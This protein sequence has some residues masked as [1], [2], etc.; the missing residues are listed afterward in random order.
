MAAKISMN[1]YT[2]EQR[3]Q[4]RIEIIPDYDSD[5][6]YGYEEENDFYDNYEP[7]EE[8]IFGEEDY[9]PFDP[10]EEEH[11]S[12]IL[13]KNR[14]VIKPLAGI[15]S[16]TKSINE[17]PSP[18]KSPTWWDITNKIDE[19]NRL[20]NGVLNYG[21]LL[22][23]SPPA[24][25][26]PVVQPSKKTKKN[27]NKNDGHQP[28]KHNEKKKKN[29]EKQPSNVKKQEKVKET[30]EPSLDKPTR[31]CLS[32]IKKVKCF[33]TNCRFAHSYNDLKECN[34][35]ERCNK[36]SMVKTNPDGTLEFINKNNGIC[37]FKHSK[38]SK[39]SYLKRVPQQYTKK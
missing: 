13:P 31:F 11:K 39:N 36:I 18:K 27:K 25:P 24:P 14:R 28:S 34:F 37:N 16:P 19:S 35:G 10:E 8:E 7:Y 2:F 6:N 29:G 4:K 1:N 30:K 32:V 15:N 23:S 38:E 9:E 21:A 20:I 33:H 3:V 26:A 12:C 17:S 5:N 22:P